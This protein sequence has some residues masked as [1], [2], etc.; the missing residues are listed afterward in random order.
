[1]FKDVWSPTADLLRTITNRSKN[2]YR[3]GVAGT[4]TPMEKSTILIGV[5][6]ACFQTLAVTVTPG[7]PAPPASVTRPVTVLVCARSEEEI[8]NRIAGNTIV[9]INFLQFISN[10]SIR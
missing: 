3:S 4:V 7:T 6:L 9:H 10:Q 1:M 8:S 5:V 2:Q